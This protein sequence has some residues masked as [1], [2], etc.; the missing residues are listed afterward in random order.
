MAVGGDA[1]QEAEADREDPSMPIERLW[2]S[3]VDIK[4]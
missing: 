2:V 1:W 4:G 3:L